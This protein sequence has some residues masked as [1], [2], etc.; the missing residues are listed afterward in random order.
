MLEESPKLT[1]Q[2]RATH[3][4]NPNKITNQPSSNQHK[5]VK[6]I[7]EQEN[8]KNSNETKQA[9]NQTKLTQK[10]YIANQNQE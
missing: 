9:F 6:R 10:Q 5:S 2:T 4:A 7:G 3:G 1:N 8:K